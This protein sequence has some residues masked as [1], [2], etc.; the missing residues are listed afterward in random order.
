MT[1]SISGERPSPPNNPFGFGP[2]AGASTSTAGFDLGNVFGRQQLTTPRVSNA[3]DSL[4]GA[5]AATDQPATMGSGST[6]NPPRP[7]GG[8]GFGFAFGQPVSSAPGDS[9]TRSNFFGNGPANLFGNPQPVGARVAPAQ[10]LFGPAPTAAAQPGASPTAAATAPPN[11]PPRPTLFG[12]GVPAPPGAIPPGA[13]VA[14]VVF[15]FGRGPPGGAPDP[16]PP[17]RRARTV[18]LRTWLEKREMEAGWRCSKEACEVFPKDGDSMDPNDTARHIKELGET[19][20]DLSL[21]ALYA[22]AWP[23]EEDEGGQGNGKAKAKDEGARGDEERKRTRGNDGARL[24]S[25]PE[26]SSSTAPEPPTPSRRTNTLVVRDEATGEQLAC[27]H[28]FHPICIIP[29]IIK[30][31][32][33]D[34]DMDGQV[35]QRIKAVCPR[36]KAEG[37]V[38]RADVDEEGMVED[39]YFPAECGHDR[40]ENCWHD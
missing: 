2:A 38:N 6:A 14:Q 22:N 19:G 12:M 31:D 34:D 3:R 36:C 33:G 16:P 23:E 25:G 32:D 8:F 4:F 28:R 27:A 18:P 11:E 37:W 17:A 13:R 21:I 24:A 39:V 40:H 15:E 35:P 5:P 7:D 26:A 29:H 20:V 9:Q 1:T 30:Q 10:S